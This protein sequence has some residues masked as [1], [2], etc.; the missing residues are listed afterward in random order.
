M[1][2]G[3]WGRAKL[4]AAVAVLATLTRAWAEY[5]AQVESQVR[6]EL[7][8]LLSGTEHGVAYRACLLS[9]EELLVE[10]T[11]ETPAGVQ[12]AEDLLAAER[13]REQVATA[14]AT[15]HPALRLSE[16]SS[17]KTAGSEPRQLIA[18][19]LTR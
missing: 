14:L 18:L 8:R 10:I 2:R 9:A 1:R 6:Q 11:L 7:A 4:M 3:I 19:E 13:V 12:G 16:L 5:P 17:F 15:N